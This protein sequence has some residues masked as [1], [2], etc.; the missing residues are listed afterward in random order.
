MPICRYPN[1]DVFG[2]GPVIPLMCGIDSHDSYVYV[3][4]LW[5][6]CIIFKIIYCTMSFCVID[7]IYNCV[8]VE[9]LSPQRKRTELVL[10]HPY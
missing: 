4:E 10:L 3:L 5:V 9:W 1:S 7:I 2:L 8:F 6:M